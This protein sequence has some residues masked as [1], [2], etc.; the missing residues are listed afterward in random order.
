M[1][2]RLLFIALSLMASNIA[3][4]S[5]DV[6][7]TTKKIPITQYHFSQEERLFKSEYNVNLVARL[8]PLS[9]TK[10]EIEK[11]FPNLDID[12]LKDLKKPESLQ[13]FCKT[14][15]KENVVPPTVQTFNFPYDPVVVLIIK[16]LGIEND[17][18]QESLQTLDP[19][20]APTLQRQYFEV[21]F[22]CGFTP[23]N[24]RDLGYAQKGIS[25]N[26]GPNMDGRNLF[27][28]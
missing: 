1:K 7:Q 26:D 15:A 12:T 2:L 24:V 25:R 22:K 18:S 28:S 3:S 11:R 20:V 8:L 6:E 14:Q 10:E 19:L 4:A 21:L 16:G 27:F 9:S 17:F 13:E 5:C 23:K